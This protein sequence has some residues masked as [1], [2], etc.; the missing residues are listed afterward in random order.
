MELVCW[1]L[2]NTRV[3][4]PWDI[5][6]YAAIKVSLIDTI[7]VSLIDTIKVSLIDG[8]CDISVKVSSSTFALHHLMWYR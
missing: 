7:K 8:C 4:V 2:Q 3:L 1:E 6:G 5:L